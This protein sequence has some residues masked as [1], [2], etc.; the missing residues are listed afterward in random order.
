MDESDIR[1]SALFLIERRGADDAKQWAARRAVEVADAGERAT[2]L[3]ILQAI[4]D[5]SPSKSAETPF[6]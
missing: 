1:R 4:L 5:V 3:R 2:W 6:N